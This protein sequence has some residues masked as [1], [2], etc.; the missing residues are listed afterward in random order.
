MK[1]AKLNEI[2]DGENSLKEHTRKCELD[3]AMWFQ[4]VTICNKWKTFARCTGFHRLNARRPPLMNATMTM[5]FSFLIYS[6]STGRIAWIVFYADRIIIIKHHR[7]S[8]CTQ[9][10]FEF[11]LQYGCVLFYAFSKWTKTPHLCSLTA[12][13]R[14]FISIIIMC[15]VR[16]FIHW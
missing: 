11:W 12:Q 4:I 1:F 2:V 16:I 13:I 3:V 5:V 14:S 15:C 7:W 8:V 6:I 9:S 10:N